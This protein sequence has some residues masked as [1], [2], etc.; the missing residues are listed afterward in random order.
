MKMEPVLDI[1]KPVVPVYWHTRGRPI[2]AG[3]TMPN[4]VTSFPSTRPLTTYTDRQEWLDGVWPYRQDFDELPAIGQP[5]SWSWLY[6]EGAQTLVYS[7]TD[8]IRTAEDP[9]TDL[10]NY[11]CS[12]QPETRGTS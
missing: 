10:E 12:S 11:Q 4:Q 6:W 1:E 2:S 9:T 8:H 5:V 3:C 7:L